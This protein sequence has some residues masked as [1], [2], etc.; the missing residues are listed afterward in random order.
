M[1]ESEKDTR[2]QFT[3]HDRTFSWFLDDF[4]EFRKNCFICIYRNCCIQMRY[5]I[6]VVTGL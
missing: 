6:V 1:V 5:R 3:L 2:V 4:R